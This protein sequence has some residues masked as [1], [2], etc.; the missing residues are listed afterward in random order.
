MPCLASGLRAHL[1]ANEFSRGLCRTEAAPI[2]IAH[3]DE[4]AR[5]NRTHSA[6]I[7]MHLQCQTYL[8]NVVPGRTPVPDLQRDRHKFLPIGSVPKPRAPQVFVS[9]RRR[10][11]QLE[12]SQ[13]TQHQLSA[14]S[15]QSSPYLAGEWLAH[16][17]KYLHLGHRGL[18][19]YPTT[20]PW[21]G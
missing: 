3:F 13:G 19:L 7:C 11:R 8:T 12:Y 15:P 4:R 5:I 2:L 9:R 6:R 14:S 18:L 16:S 1:Q 20:S 10:S 21:D 17:H